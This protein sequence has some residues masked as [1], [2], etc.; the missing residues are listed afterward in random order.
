MSIFSLLFQY[1]SEPINTP[2]PSFDCLTLSNRSNSISSSAPS[3]ESTFDSSP[4]P[5][6]PTLPSFNDELQFSSHN[7][8]KSKD[9]V[10]VLYVNINGEYVPIAKTSLIMR[11]TLPAPKPI[12]TT[13]IPRKKNYL[14]THPGCT[15]AYFKSS[16]LKAHFRLHTG[17]ELTER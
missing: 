7:R 10:H 13:T 2:L 11:S 9:D 1:I 14:C 17:K 15:K 12:V 8:S 6:P 3:D 4:T 16:H 5:S